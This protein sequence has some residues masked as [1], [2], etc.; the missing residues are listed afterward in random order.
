MIDCTLKIETKFFK[1][2]VGN[3]ITLKNPSYER[4][5]R[6]KEDLRRLLKVAIIRNREK[7]SGIHRTLVTIIS[8]SSNRQ[9]KDEFR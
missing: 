7:L 9:F 3:F 2:I 5:N 4:R 1:I 6:M 8:N